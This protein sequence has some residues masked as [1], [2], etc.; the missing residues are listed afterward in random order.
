MVLIVYRF[1]GQENPKF[2][3]VS[4][5]TEVLTKSKLSFLK[6]TLQ[7]APC[8]KACNEQF[9][10]YQN[11]TVFTNIFGTYNRDE[12]HGNQRQHARIL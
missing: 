9:D 6:Q 12:L 7:I 10:K 1:V 2:F 11:A 5:I 3:H 8:T 4:K